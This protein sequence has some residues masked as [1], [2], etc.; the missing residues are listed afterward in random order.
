MS[1]TILRDDETLEQGTA[2]QQA[3]AATEWATP[4][5]SEQSACA[6]IGAYVFAV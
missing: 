4:E 3:Q 5:L 1:E 6:E 2:A